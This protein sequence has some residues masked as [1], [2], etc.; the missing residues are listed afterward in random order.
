MYDSYSFCSHQTAM[1][2]VGCLIWDGMEGRN[3]STEI[4]NSPFTEQQSKGN[5]SY[6]RFVLLLQFTLFQP[7]QF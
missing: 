1:L 5:Y 2:Y 3:E 7:N 6:I 4:I